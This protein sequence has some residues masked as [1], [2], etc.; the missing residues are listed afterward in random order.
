ME[1]DRALLLASLRCAA[2][3]GRLKCCTARRCFVPIAAQDFAGTVGKR[4]DSP[5]KAGRQPSW[6]KIKNPDYSSKEV[7]GFR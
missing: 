1:P 5:Y 3:P 2:R 7:L 4:L 6:L